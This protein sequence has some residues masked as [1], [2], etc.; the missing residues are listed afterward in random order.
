MP[1]DQQPRP[2]EVL[3]VEDSPTDVLIAR[4]ALNQAK[5]YNRLHVVED[6]QAALDFL[7]RPA[8]AGPLPDVVLLD[9]NL[10]RKSGR[11]V[12]AEIKLDP[13]L[14]HIPVVVLTTSRAEEDILRAYDLY[15]NCYVVKPLDF[16]SFVEV[17]RSIR[18]FWF[19][20]VTLPSE[21]AHGLDHPASAAD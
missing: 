14:R 10:P 18:H 8:A 1:A 16:N 2:V 15:A 9:W 21:T 20:V 19:S 6:G 13:A 12:L 5:L 11:E 17:V 7:R 3:L 4:E